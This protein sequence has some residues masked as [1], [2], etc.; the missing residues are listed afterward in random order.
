LYPG[1]GGKVV[2]TAPEMRAGINQGGAAR[3]KKGGKTPD[4]LS[5]PGI[6]T[7]GEVRTRRGRRGAPDDS[8]AGVHEPWPSVPRALTGRI[9]YM[10][11]LV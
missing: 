9:G 8:C 7:R 5:P 3:A 4:T 10:A 11:Q 6:V 2:A 1:Q